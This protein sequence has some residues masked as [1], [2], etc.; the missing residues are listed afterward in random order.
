MAIALDPDV[1]LAHGDTL[2]LRTVDGRPQFRGEFRT[3]HAEQSQAR[4]ARRRGKVRAAV[5]TEVENLQ[6]LIDDESRRGVL[7]EDKPVRFLL[8]VE[9]RLG[10]RLDCRR[11]NSSFVA[12]N[13]G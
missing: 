9:P 12:T 8:H 2:L 6:A 1:F 3:H 10:F 11:S 5:P 4:L 13:G 7:A